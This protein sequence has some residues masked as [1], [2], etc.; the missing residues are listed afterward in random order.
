MIYIKS[1][2]FIITLSTSAVPG[3]GLWRGSER[4]ALGITKNQKKTFG[5]DKYVSYFNCDNDFTCVN[6]HQNTICV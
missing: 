5:D 4:W 1:L 6:I 3:N 2:I